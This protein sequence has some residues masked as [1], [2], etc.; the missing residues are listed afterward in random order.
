MKNK[1]IIF[2]TL[3]VIAIV[4][5]ISAYNTFGRKSYSQAPATT[6]ISIKKI[7]SQISADGIITSEN[8]ATLNFQTA[9]KLV[10]LPFKEGDHVSQGQAIARLDTYAL[11]RQLSAALN[12]YRATRDTFDQVQQNS[13]DNQLQASQRSSFSSVQKDKSNAIDDAVKR[14]VDQSQ[15]SLDNSIVNVELSNYALQLSTLTAP[16]NGI[17]LHQDPTV[18]NVNITT[19]TTF[20]IADPDT[21]V[22]KANVNA[23]DIDFIHPGD[24]AAIKINGSD[25]I[26]QGTISKIYPQ[27]TTLPSG[28][29]VYKV[30]IQSDS[31]KNNIKLEQAGS[32]LISNS[33]SP[34]VALVPAWT[35]VGH[36]YLWVME[37]GRA[38]LKKVK[39]GQLHGEEIEILQGIE[40]GDQVIIDP[41]SI[42]VSRYQ[43][44]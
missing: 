11:Q 5:A 35:V 38:V 30:D 20:T 42:A 28:E 7:K 6:V 18:P 33:Q 1:Q 36:Q 4:L 31:F 39:L 29:E 40:A 22:F 16:I 2:L 23:A 32:V 41:E 8:Q 9:G 14:I 37:N 13:Q 17:I 24:N 25:K 27:K 19:A 34:D 21:P 10:Y 12:S 3:A 26:Y 44:L 43:I 15:A